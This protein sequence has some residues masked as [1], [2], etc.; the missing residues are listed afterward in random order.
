[1]KDVFITDIHIKD[2]RHLKDVHI[3]LSDKERKHLILTG[4]NGSGKTSVVQTLMYGIELDQGEMVTRRWE[5]KNVHNRINIKYN[6][7]E[8][9]RN[10][11]FEKNGILK[12]FNAIRT[13]SFIKPKGA[14]KIEYNGKKKKKSLNFLWI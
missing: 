3:H 14:N 5:E 8:G 13:T 2:V 12:F 7:E 4:R 6:I 11:E 9:L 1:M 10:S